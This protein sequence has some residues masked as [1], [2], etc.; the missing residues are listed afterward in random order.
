MFFLCLLNEMEKKCKYIVLYPKFCSFF[1]W[2]SFI[3]VFYQYRR[4]LG[5]QWI[6]ADKSRLIFTIARR[7]PDQLKAAMKNSFEFFIGECFDSHRLELST[8][9]F[10]RTSRG[11][12]NQQNQWLDG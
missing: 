7:T 9:H 1:N 2:R 10:E 6:A 8:R 3:F 5:E 11:I 4:L 12:S